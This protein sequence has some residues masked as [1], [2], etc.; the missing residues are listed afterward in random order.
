MKE[1]S[2]ADIQK[3]IE[4]DIE[5]GKEMIEEGKKL[6]D[7]GKLKILESRKKVRE[8]GDEA[9]IKLREFEEKYQPE[10]EYVLKES[11][12]VYQETETFIKK[13]PLMSVFAAFGVGY[14]LGK[15]LR[16]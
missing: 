3:E 8:L 1:V 2:V 11:E 14:V 13:Y 16:K 10:L 15:L 7:E 6:L 4:K 12:K 9:G 5:K